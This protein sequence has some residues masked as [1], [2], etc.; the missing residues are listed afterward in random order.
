MYT[1]KQK[2]IVRSYGKWLSN[3]DWNIFSTFTYRFNIREKQNFNIMTKLE[4]YLKSQSL[5]FRMFWVMEYTS[6]QFSTHNHFLIKGKGV[7]KKIEY[8]LK[9]KGLITNNFKHLD[10]E[11]GA[12]MYVSKYI[13]NENIK[14]NYIQSK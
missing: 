13:C 4:K 1:N 6:N 14:Y 11:R 12:S 8:H 3:M 9:E 7:E 10:Y 5:S 2:E